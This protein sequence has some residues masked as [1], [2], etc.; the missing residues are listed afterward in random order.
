[1]NENVWYV[2]YAKKKQVLRRK[3]KKTNKQTNK[4]SESD[5]VQLSTQ[6]FEKSTVH[7]H[8][9]PHHTTPSLCT[10]HPTLVTSPARSSIP[11]RPLTRTHPLRIIPIIRIELSAPRPGRPII[12]HRRLQPVL[13]PESLCVLR[14]P[15]SHTHPPRRAPRSGRIPRS[16]GKRRTPRRIPALLSRRL[17][18]LARQIPHI[19]PSTPTAAIAATIPPM[20]APVWPVL[21][22]APVDEDELEPVSDPSAVPDAESRRTEEGSAAAAEVGCQ[23]V[24]MAPEPTRTYVPL[25]SR[26]R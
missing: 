7:H 1:M 12:A 3:S 26:S 21:S 20:I 16:R 24:S 4:E 18:L 14:S 17:R 15:S 10:A 19:A 23:W 25:G 6:K 11:R 22:P 13:V 8:T 9:T 5:Q 2:G